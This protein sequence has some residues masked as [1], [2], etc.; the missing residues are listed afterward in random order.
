MKNL[1]LNY[2]ELQQALLAVQLG[3]SAAIKQAH[4]H[5]YLSDAARHHYGRNRDSNYKSLQ[6]E[7][8]KQLKALDKLELHYKNLEEKIIE[9]VENLSFKGA[10]DIKFN[11]NMN[12][13]IDIRKDHRLSDDEFISW[14]QTIA[15]AKF[16]PYQIP[17]PLIIQDKLVIESKKQGYDVLSDDW[18]DISNFDF[19]NIERSENTLLACYLLLKEDAALLYNIIDSQ[20]QHGL[21]LPKSYLKEVTQSLLTIKG[22][23]WFAKLR[24]LIKAIM[25]EYNDKFT[26]YPCGF[27]T[28]SQEKDVQ[29]LREQFFN[30]NWLTEQL[31]LKAGQPGSELYQLTQSLLTVF[32]SIDDGLDWQRAKQ[33]RLS[34]QYC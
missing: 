26:H 24:L 1:D 14:H 15:Q 8:K 17:A 23:A 28:E 13:L 30:M 11:R 19:F 3:I 9:S 22:D 12:L 7:I 16:K 34:Q 27:T 2:L 6:S 32:L 25:R 21:L 20:I 5:F 10:S 33:V 18:L 29:I 31:K 4:Y